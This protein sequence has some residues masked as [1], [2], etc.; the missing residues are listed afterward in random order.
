MV[1]TIL[2]RTSINAPHAFL[3]ANGRTSAAFAARRSRAG[4]GAEAWYPLE[5]LL[6]ELVAAMDRFP[7][8]VTHGY[9]RG[10]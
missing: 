6:D 10:P 1:T 9:N 5:W 8:D 4:W 2:S 3:D 7:R